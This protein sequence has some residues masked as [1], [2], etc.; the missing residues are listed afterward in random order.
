VSDEDTEEDEE[1]DEAEEEETTEAEYVTTISLGEALQREVAVHVKIPAWAPLAG[2][3][4]LVAY[5]WIVGFVSG[6]C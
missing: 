3:T 5:L 4:A 6:R 2:F 1:D